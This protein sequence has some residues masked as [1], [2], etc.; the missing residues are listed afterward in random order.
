MDGQHIGTVYG[1]MIDAAG[2]V[3]NVSRWVADAVHSLL[4]LPRPV[5]VDGGDEPVA[6]PRWGVSG[7]APGAWT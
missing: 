2:D 7:P 4:G 1:V 6:A 5:A 3:A